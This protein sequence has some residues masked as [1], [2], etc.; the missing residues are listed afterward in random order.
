MTNSNET[1]LRENSHILYELTE[2]SGDITETIKENFKKLSR[3][4]HPDKNPEKRELAE[5]KFKALTAFKAKITDA[6]NT[7]E[8][9]ANLKTQYPISSL[10]FTFSSAFGAGHKSAPTKT[11]DKPIDP[12]KPEDQQFFESFKKTYYEKSM[13]LVNHF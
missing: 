3:K 11:E 8:T 13:Y 7:A 10:D 4:Y 6:N 1:N 5:E 9:I 2:G 12:I